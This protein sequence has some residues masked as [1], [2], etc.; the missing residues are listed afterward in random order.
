MSV[1]KPRRRPWLL[2]NRT[3]DRLLVLLVPLAWFIYS[4]WRPLYELRGEMPPQFV[5]VPAAASAADKGREQRLAQAYWKMARTAIRP[6]YIYGSTL[7][8]DPPPDFD[9]N[10]TAAAVPAFYSAKVST[11][12]RRVRKSGVGPK[13]ASSARVRYWHKF[14]QVWLEPYAWQAHQE[15]STA[16]FT[17]PIRRLYI[18]VQNYVSNRFRAT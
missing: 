4:S 16:W 9:V 8:S 12:N 1:V 15:W 18:N 5:D 13:D 2:Y 6:R 7:P 10:S 11:A 14:Q 3:F 17:S